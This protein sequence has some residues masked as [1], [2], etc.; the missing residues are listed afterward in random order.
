MSDCDNIKRPILP[1]MIGIMADS[2]GNVDALQS[3][4]TFFKRAGC[5]ALF[6]LG[7]VCD[8]TLPETTAPCVA[9]IQDSN[10]LAVKGNNEH[11]VSVNAPDDGDSTIP[12]FLGRLPIIRSLPGAVFA[13]SL[14]FEKELGLS[15]MIRAIND[16]AARMFFRQ[17][18]DSVLFRGH[19]HAPVLMFE[20]NGAIQSIPISTAKP[21]TIASLRPCI[22]TAGALTDGL[23]MIWDTVADDI[24]LHA[25]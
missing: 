8:S 6:H 18:P 23:C 4:V 10:V 11:T 19:S 25:L 14:P 7:D 15:A 24:Q 1:A 3:A 16:D 2:H 21:V 22:I 20:K 12:L 13:H 17:Y 9:I 5:R